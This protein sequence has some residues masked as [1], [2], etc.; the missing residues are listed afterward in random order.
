MFD[1]QIKCRHG[2]VE[3]K[4]MILIHWNDTGLLGVRI[5]EKKSL[6]KV[7]LLPHSENKSYKGGKPAV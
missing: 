1:Q 3:K 7:A 6:I 2:M 5:Y 4:S